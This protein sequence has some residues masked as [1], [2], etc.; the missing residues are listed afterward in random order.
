[1]NSKIKALKTELKETALKIRSMKN[2]R[3]VA[4]S[5]YVHGLLK[6]QHDYRIK[7][8]TYCIARGRTMEQIEPKVKDNNIL[9]EWQLGVISTMVEVLQVA[10]VEV[11]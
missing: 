1:M 5:G 4:N 11:L 6:L 3:C 2:E 10:D 7:H 8:I 9:S